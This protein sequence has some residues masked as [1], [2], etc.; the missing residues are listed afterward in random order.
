MLPIILPQTMCPK[1]RNFARWRPPS[2]DLSKAHFT[3]IVFI[4]GT[5]F[6]GFIA[7][8][9]SALTEFGTPSTFDTELPQVVLMVTKVV[10]GYM[11]LLHHTID[12]SN[13]WLTL[14]LVKLFPMA[15]DILPWRN[16]RNEEPELRIINVN[17]NSYR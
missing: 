1:L 4:L 8:L 14:A 9:L 16:L 3:W 17:Q 11:S 7:A 12:A 5:E 6:N 10:L 15:V 13:F 2:M